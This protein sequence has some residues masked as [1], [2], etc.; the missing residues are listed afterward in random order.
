VNVNRPH[1]TWPALGAGQQQGHRIGATTQGHS[2]RKARTE[3]S[4]GL[5]GRFGGVL[6]H[7]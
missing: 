5:F 3:L 6:R 7:V 2:K 1:L 4:Q